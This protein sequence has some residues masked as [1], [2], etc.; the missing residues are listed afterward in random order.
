MPDRIVRLKLPKVERVIDFDTPDG[1][2]RYVW[3]ETPDK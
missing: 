3:E 1:Y 2:D